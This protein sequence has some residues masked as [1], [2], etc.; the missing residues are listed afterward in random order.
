MKKIKKILKFF[1]IWVGFLRPFLKYFLF[2]FLI[3]LYVLYNDY[4]F[5]IYFRVFILLNFFFFYKS[6][7]RICVEN[8]KKLK[9]FFLKNK[10]FNKFGIFVYKYTHIFFY[11]LILNFYIIEF[12]KI[13]RYILI[14]KL[15]I[16]FIMD[17]IDFIYYFIIFLP[18][19]CFL[20]QVIDLF[21]HFKNKIV[22][23]S[24]SSFINMRIFI[25]FISIFIS[26]YY[27][28]IYFIL[29]LTYIKIKPF[30]VYIYYIILFTLFILFLKSLKNL[31]KE[32]Y[33]YWFNKSNNRVWL[34]EGLHSPPLCLFKQS[35]IKKIYDC[36]FFLSNCFFVIKEKQKIIPSKKLID[37][38]I[39]FDGLY[40]ENLYYYNYIYYK[41]DIYGNIS[42]IKFIKFLNFLLL[43]IF[44]LN[45][46][47]WYLTLF[48]KNNKVLDNS[49]CIL[50]K[51]KIS[52]KIEPYITFNYFD[53]IESY[54]YLN[55]YKFHECKNNYEVLLYDCKKIFQL[56]D[57][58]EIIYNLIINQNFLLDDLDSD[59]CFENIFISFEFNIHKFK[60][61]N[62]KLNNSF[63]NKLDLLEKNFDLAVQQDIFLDIT[64]SSLS[65]IGLGITTFMIDDFEILYSNNFSL[66]DLQ[67]LESK[68][69]IDVENQLK[70]IYTKE[71]GIRKNLNRASHFYN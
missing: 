21:W 46:W 9:I 33:F 57:N 38:L 52:Y 18:I 2:Y 30:N 19:F 34:E 1:F 53:V 56:F 70:K 48:E 10:K 40:I 39:I 51:D 25:L 64:G 67:N 32:Y 31:K 11:F 20:E 49:I 60:F 26:F 3:M 63:L 61:S 8:K 28:K 43:I 45:F 69:L 44:K 36:R 23:Q 68:N 54:G 41:K 59:S 5:N 12:L 29:G 71:I 42:V 14:I 65:S 4:L 27:F 55:L 50:K 58:D 17:I 35:N 62:T 15:N 22:S 66:N 47:N 7:Y 13:L 37:T 16:K 24:Y 6:L